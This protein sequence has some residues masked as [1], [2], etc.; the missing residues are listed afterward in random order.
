MTLL[1][2]V[3]IGY[4]V[5]RCGRWFYWGQVSRQLLAQPPARAA[6]EVSLARGNDD[7][8]ETF[9]RLNRK[10]ASS[11]T[12]RGSDRRN[13]L[14]TLRIVYHAVP[15]GERVKVRCLVYC[16]PQDEEQ[17]RRYLK[18]DFSGSARLARFND[19][20]LSGFEP[21]AVSA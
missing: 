6:F 7:S 20:P 16:D 5:Y 13:G 18:E 1:L 2:A 12:P 8:V 17:L 21:A 11:L 9:A 14:A 3:G 4:V 15:D 10:L 19:D